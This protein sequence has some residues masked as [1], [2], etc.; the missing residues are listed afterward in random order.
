MNAELERVATLVAGL[1]YEI[2]HVTMDTIR[3]HEQRL[4]AERARLAAQQEQLSRAEYDLGFLTALSA[5]PTRPKSDG[6]Q[7]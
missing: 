7:P 2:V 3:E 5:E 6:P 4:T 1:R